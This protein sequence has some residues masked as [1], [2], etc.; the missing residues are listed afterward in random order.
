MSLFLC[1]FP[2]MLCFTRFT[3]RNINSFHRYMT[4]LSSSERFTSKIVTTV[5]EIAEN[6]GIH[7]IHLNEKRLSKEGIAEIARKNDYLLFILHKEVIHSSSVLQLIPLNQTSKDHRTP[8]SIDF[9]SIKW[10]NRFKQ[11]RK[12]LVVKAFGKASPVSLSSFSVSSAPTSPDMIIDLTAGLGRDSMILALGSGRRVIMVEQNTVLFL[13]LQNALDRYKLINPTLFKENNLV[14]LHGKAQDL[15]PKIQ[16]LISSCS[17][18]TTY[19][20]SHSAAATSSFPSSSQALDVGNASQTSIS[21]PKISVYLDP[22][23]SDPHDERKSAVKKETQLIN[24]ILSL[25]DEHYHLLS[26][27][28]HLQNEQQLFSIAKSLANDRIVVKRDISASSLK[29]VETRDGNERE[30]VN[31][32]RDERGEIL[33]N[34]IYPHSLIKGNTQRFDIYYCNQLK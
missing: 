3:R 4:R 24:E 23:Y 10:K 21:S 15:A 17:N 13:L 29:L 20:S 34:S 26:E 33:E 30:R 28:Q 9:N 6:Y 7:Y 19:L 18:I 16:T 31:E 27:S 1:G 5:P 25:T 32:E 22:M 8:F 14:L 2:S 11:A 12:E